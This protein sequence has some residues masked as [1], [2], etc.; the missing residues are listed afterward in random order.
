TRLCAALRSAPDAQRQLA[1][2]LR[3]GGGRDDLDRRRQRLKERGEVAGEGEGLRPQRRQARLLEDRER[4]N[5]RGGREHGRIAHRPG[6]RAA[7]RR[8]LRL[9]EKARGLFVTPPA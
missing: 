6:S 5:E 2:T 4:G 7:R 8:E 3:R 1:A 9:H